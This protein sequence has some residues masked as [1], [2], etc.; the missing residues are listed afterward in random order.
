MN[1]VTG[2]V[3][4]ASP[5]TLEKPACDA[6][7]STNDAVTL[8]PT[9]GRLAALVGLLAYGLT[10]AAFVLSYSHTASYMAYLLGPKARPWEIYLSA[11]LPE[12]M[13]I[14]CLLALKIGIRGLWVWAPLLSA[15]AVVILANVT[16]V[17]A[18]RSSL[19]AALMYPISS[20]M[21]LKLKLKLQ[22]AKAH[23][24]L[25]PEPVSAS[26]E[27]ELELVSEPQ[28]SLEPEPVSLSPEPVRRSP[29]AQTQS[30]PDELIEKIKASPNK[31]TVA[32]L[33]EKHGIS[34]ATAGRRRQAAGVT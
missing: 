29:K 15:Y 12:V 24:S 6:N 8:D 13:V 9:G 33:M 31:Y 19:I 5:V 11:A 20:L 16:Q 7:L 32:Y 1:S 34:R 14:T 18:H 3:T 22:E 4:L 27:P 28:M 23:V 26:R 10:A 21:L 30:S 2:S 17:S 25:S